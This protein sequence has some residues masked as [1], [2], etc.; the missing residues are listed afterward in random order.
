M[1]MV[2]SRSILSA[3][4]LANANNI[5]KFSDS[6]STL[7]GSK[8]LFILSVPDSAIE[9]AASLLAEQDIDFSASLCIHL[10]GSLTIEAL[11][12][13]QS[14]GASTGSIHIMQ[15]FPSHKVQNIA[16]TSA[17]IEAS[18]DTAGQQLYLFAQKLQLKP[19]TIQS[20]YKIF[21]HLSGVFIS[22]FLVANFANAE[23]SIA[24]A[25]IEEEK[26]E[27]ILLPTFHSTLENITGKGT[28]ESLSGPIIRADMSV[29]IKHVTA[30]KKLSGKSGLFR[31]MLI[32]YIGQSLS[33]LHI[34]RK[35]NKEKSEAYD[36]IEQYLNDELR[37][38]TAVKK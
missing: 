35:K 4:S 19:F 9:D 22:N 27:S 38:L 12:P 10:S 25:E 23:N 2:I 34:A 5:Q 31:D 3:Q 13:L 15:T 36:A 20:E 33:L 11:L 28:K 8:G 30:L 21:Y 1:D 32:A 26:R 16:N 37:N 29:I 7:S 14:K 6:Y 18:S 24:A 17:A